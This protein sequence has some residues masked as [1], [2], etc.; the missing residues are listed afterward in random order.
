MKN[1][2]K[3]VIKT[4]TT[5]TVTEEIVEAK[6]VETHYLLI[7]DE[8]GSMAGL[9]NQTINNI[10]EQIQI[11]RALEK[12]YTDQKYFISLITFNTEV[13]ER[14]MNIP[15]LEM[16][17]VSASDYNPDGGT[18]LRDAM[19][20]GITR[21]EDKLRPSMEDHSKIVT[22]VVV[23]ITDGEENASSQWSAEKTKTLVERMNK[24]DKW[25]ISYIG[26]NQNAILTGSQYGVYAGN[27]I[28]YVSTAAG[29]RG[30]ANTLAYTMSSRASTI[31]LGGYSFIGG[32]LSNSSFMD[33]Q[34]TSIQEST[35]SGPIDIDKIINQT[36]PK[37]DTTTEDTK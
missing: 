15:V 10:N 35:T 14:Y 21:L 34:G 32:G 23:I 2:P 12:K 27:S 33:S 6:L 26:A 24:D 22:A 28:N 8:S 3:K 31:N 36:D 20:I 37:D 30:L 16:K 11:V 7:V 17:E 13:K 4:T 25:T 1:N 9:R 18:A 19:G 5:T 29:T